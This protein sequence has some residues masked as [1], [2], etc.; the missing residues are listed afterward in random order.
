[1]LH[2]VIMVLV[3]YFSPFLIW[4]Y[5]RLILYNRSVLNKSL[6]VIQSFDTAIVII[7]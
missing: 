1:V 5:G 2:A 7:K 4:D 6:Y 3:P